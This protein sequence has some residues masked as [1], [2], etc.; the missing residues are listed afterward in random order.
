MDE[1][2]DNESEAMN[3]E[4]EAELINRRDA[5]R[6]LKVN[7]RTV[8]RM[9]TDG[10]LTPIKKG[11][12]DK[13][14][15]FYRED[16][17]DELRVSRKLGVDAHKLDTAA[18]S[19][20]NDAAVN[21]AMAPSLMIRSSGK[22]ME[23]A[24]DHVKELM[25]PVTSAMKMNMEVLMKEN[26]RLTDRSTKL[27]GEIFEFIDLQKKAMRDDQEA[28][29]VEITELENLKMKKET[30]DRLTGYMPLIATLI[31]DRLS[32]AQRSKVRESALTDIVEK[33]S[34]DQ[35]EALQKSGAFGQAEMATIISMKQR[36][37]AERAERLKKEAES[38][39]D[40]EDVKSG[41]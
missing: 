11:E 40:A 17:V 20:V 37:E 26:R 16:E 29:L 2:E 33:M 19:V 21:M 25:S 13:A 35:I 32:P 24:Q 38:A 27:E 9:E 1:N 6:L 34:F 41:S 14:P 30:F 12:G 23:I 8:I 22:A 10:Y 15:I 5:A 4:E 3:P 39:Q 7:T 31:G 36:M 28:K 18:E